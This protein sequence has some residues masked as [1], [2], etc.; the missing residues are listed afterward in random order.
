MDRA[1]VLGTFLWLVQAQMQVG[2]VVM[3]NHADSDGFVGIQ[4]A[5]EEHLGQRQGL[6]VVLAGIDQVAWLK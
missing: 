1:K 5:L 3:G 4:P 6:Q 2:Q